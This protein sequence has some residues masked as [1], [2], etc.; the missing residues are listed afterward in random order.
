MQIVEY[1]ITHA[2]RYQG[3]KITRLFLI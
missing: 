3:M 1:L 2:K